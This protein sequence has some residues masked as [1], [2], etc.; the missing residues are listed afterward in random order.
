MIK[1]LVSHLDTSN[2]AILLMFL[3]G[4]R[5]GEVVTLRHSDF[6]DN[7]FNVRR[8]ETKYKDENGN[9]VVEVKEYPKTKAG[10]RT[11][12]IPS[13]YVWICDK[14]KHM[15]PFGDYIFTKNDIRIT[16]R[17]LDKGRKGFAGN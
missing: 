7:T 1:Y 14:I 12:I 6:S 9:N 15:N 13:D 8:T 4:V 11:A 10:I 17:R 2:V 3:T 16:H 5:I